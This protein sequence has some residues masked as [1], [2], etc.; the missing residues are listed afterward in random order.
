M[1]KISFF[2][3]FVTG[4][5]LLTGLLLFPIVA[6]HASESAEKSGE[7]AK[8]EKTE[9]GDKAEAGDKKDAKKSKGSDVVTG[10]RFSGDPIYVHIRPMFMPVVTDNGAEQIVTLMVDLRVDNMNVANSFQD[11]MPRVRDAL[12]QVLYGGLSNG[13]LR[14]G[15]LIDVAKVKEK[16]SGAIAKVMGPEAVQEVLIQAIAQRRM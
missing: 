11:N 9:G 5:A 3:S 15:Q 12:M 10:G 16:I 6:L 14:Q 4:F 8:T 13:S 2:V 7:A 1:K